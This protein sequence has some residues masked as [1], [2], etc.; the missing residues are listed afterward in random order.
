VALELLDLAG[1]AWIGFGQSNASLNILLTFWW[2]IP[3]KVSDSE[4]ARLF[5]TDFYGNILVLERF[6]FKCIPSVGSPPVYF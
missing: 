1:Q 2:L 4:H 6:G 3:L 5:Q